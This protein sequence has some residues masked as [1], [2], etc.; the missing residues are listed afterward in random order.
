MPWILCI[1]KEQGVVL[2][3][4]FG[5]CRAE[6]LPAIQKAVR[7]DLDFK[8]SFR[9]LFDLRGIIDLKLSPPEINR[10]AKNSPFDASARK[11]FLIDRDVVRG[12]ARTYER[13]S[14]VGKGG[15]KIFDD[16][17]K[18]KEWLCIH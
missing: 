16:M 1:D 7:D 13:S 11:A 5:T 9:A 18:A 12:F 17:A 10:M 4:Q 2:V 8:P 6:E 3:D 15:F 14:I